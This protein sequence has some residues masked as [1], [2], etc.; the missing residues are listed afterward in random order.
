MAQLAPSGPVYQAGTLSGNPVATAA[1]LATLRRCDDAV[2]AHLDATAADGRRAGRP[3]ALDE[4]GRAAP[5]AARREPV[6][7]LL[8]RRRRCATTRRRAPRRPCRYPPFF[9]A[10]LAGGVYAAAV[11]VRGLVRLRRARR[12]RARADRRRAARRGPRGRRGARGAPVTRARRSASHDRVHLV[13]HGE[14]DNPG[15]VLYGRLPGYHLS[16]LGRQMADR[17]AEWARRPRRRRWS[18]PRRSS[19]RRRR[20][21]RSPRAHGL[22]GRQ[23]RAA[24][25]GG[26]PLR[27]AG[28]RGRRRVAAGTR[29]T[30]RT[31]STRCARRGASRTSRSPPGCSAAVARRRAA[32]RRAARPCWSATS[33]RSG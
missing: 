6:H 3:T 13:R 16:A 21:R 31:W 19:A 17:V 7:R 9:H 10:M 15:K 32:R 20:R 5:R 2:Y 24:D 30:G 27:G 22:G 4:A 23:R 25:R 18:S 1:G 11:G 14:V 28:V 8:R 26:Q 33:C 29:G 12:R